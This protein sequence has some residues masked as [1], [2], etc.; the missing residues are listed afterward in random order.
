MPLLVAASL[1]AVEGA[2][3][4]TYGLL[5]AAALSQGRLTMGVTTAGFFLAFGAL[6][7]LCA[8]SLRGLN[9]WAR[10]PALLAQ[11]V[12]LG[13]AWNFRN[14]STLPVAL[15]LALVAMLVLA[16][17]LHPASIAAL[18]DAPEERRAQGAP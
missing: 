2:V 5:E 3:L 4:V 16:G 8:W 15:T 14:G 7:I 18:A 10:G 9:A 6:L 17:L 11:L 1:V 12:Q 13:L